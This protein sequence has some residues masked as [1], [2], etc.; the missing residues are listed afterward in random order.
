MGTRQHNILASIQ[1]VARSQLHQ[2]GLRHA[3]QLLPVHLLPRHVRA[4]PRGPHPR[5]RRGPPGSSA[6]W[7]FPDDG[8]LRTHP[9]V[10]TIPVPGPSC[11]D[12]V[13]EKTSVRP[14]RSTFPPSVLSRCEAAGFADE[15][16]QAHLGGEGASGSGRG[17]RF[18]VG[19]KTAALLVQT[20]GNQR[21]PQ[22]RFA[23]FTITNRGD[24]DQPIWAFTI[25][26][27]RRGY[28]HE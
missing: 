6:G 24:H 4:E 11:D 18:S 15:S 14:G 19:R 2:L 9:S 23:P 12:G 20:T 17:S 8:T 22:R 13:G 7:P 3:A 5:P 16:L 28:D 10:R 27:M 21:Q 26:G 25:S 1:V